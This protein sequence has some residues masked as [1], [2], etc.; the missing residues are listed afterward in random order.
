MAR[1]FPIVLDDELNRKIE[2]FMLRENFRTKREC[3]VYL[4]RKGLGEEG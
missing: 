4:I 3:I 2:E 1:I